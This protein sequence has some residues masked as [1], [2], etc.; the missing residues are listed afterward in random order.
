MYYFISPC[1]EISDFF[2]SKKN[3]IFLN[4]EIEK[5]SLK[6]LK[7]EFNLLKNSDLN[8][9]KNFGIY[10]EIKDSIEETEKL[11]DEIE[12]QKDFY[13]PS[14][15]SRKNCSLLFCSKSCDE[16]Y[17]EHL[18]KLT[19]T[20]DKINSKIN[21]IRQTLFYY[22]D[23]KKN[24]RKYETE[25]K[26]LIKKVDDYIKYI[27][28]YTNQKATQ[29]NFN[30]KEIVDR[31]SFYKNKL[32][33]IKKK[34]L[35]AIDDE[36]FYLFSKFINEGIKS[37]VLGIYTEYRDT[38][39]ELDKDYF[40][41]LKNKKVEYKVILSL[42]SWDDYQDYPTEHT[43]TAELKV[44]K[45]LYEKMENFYKNT[46]GEKPIC[47]GKIY[48]PICYISDRNLEVAVNWLIN[49]INYS[50]TD[51]EVYIEEIY[52]IYYHLYEIV[53]SNGT[54]ETKWV[55]VDKRT[56]ETFKELNTVV[57]AKP[58]GYFEDQIKIEPKDIYNSVINNPY[59]SN[60]NNPDI[61]PILWIIR[62]RLPEI[63]LPDKN[64]PEDFRKNRML[65]YYSR[66]KVLE[67]YAKKYGLDKKKLEEY[68]KEGYTG[69]TVSTSSGG[70]GIGSRYRGGGYGGFGK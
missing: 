23:G 26:E 20:V 12:K 32:L 39:K 36:N 60:I 21:N 62:N 59:Y 42:Y 24:I 29:Y 53:S 8:N 10:K 55:E 7:K 1:S 17:S 69:S 65:D 54:K 15:F 40:V 31:G 35:K 19:H 70:R 44:P 52:P 66:K 46:G 2:I 49:R 51:F 30:Y 47:S 28:N 34:I 27:E 11:I 56:F 33:E 3:S 25:L 18:V 22:K 13:E 58:L 14:T 61:Y 68:K 63:S 5:K 4:L 41:V 45:Q 57:I 50:D 9:L 48:S 16:I 43:L 67:D 37:K 64:Y 6:E 38:F